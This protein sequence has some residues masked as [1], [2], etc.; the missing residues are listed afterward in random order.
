MKLNVQLF[1]DWN[2]NIFYDIQ[3]TSNVTTPE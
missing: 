2:I 1:I 3:Q